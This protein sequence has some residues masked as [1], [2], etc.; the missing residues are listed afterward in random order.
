MK[1]HRE[2]GGSL[3][4][5]SAKF[6][7]MGRWEIMFRQNLDRFRLL[8]K[9]QQSNTP[10]SGVTPRGGGVGATSPSSKDNKR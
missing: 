10:Q 8:P 3:G 1:H 2:S 5:A 7:L 4:V 6:P 9:N